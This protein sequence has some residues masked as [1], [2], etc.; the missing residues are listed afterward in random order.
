MITRRRVPLALVILFVAGFLLLIRTKADTPSEDTE[1][2]YTGSI[3]DGVRYSPVLS[4]SQKDTFYLLADT[5][6]ALQFRKTMI[7]FWDTTQEYKADWGKLNETVEGDLEIDSGQ[8]QVLRTSLKPMA[9]VRQTGE[10]IFS[11]VVFGDEAMRR[12]KQYQ[13]DIQ[14][15]QADYQK[16]QDA[17]QAYQQELFDRYQNPDK[18]KDAGPLVE[19]PEPPSLKEYLTDL[20]PA[21][22]VLL[23][24]GTYRMRVIDK[25]GQIVPGSEKN[26]KVFRQRREGISYIVY[27]EQQWTTQKVSREVNDDIYVGEAASLYLQPLFQYEYYADDYWN[28]EQP[29]KVFDR[30]DYWMW[31]NIRPIQSGTL[32]IASDGGK[33]DSVGFQPFYVQQVPGDTLGYQIVDVDPGQPQTRISFSAFKVDLSGKTAFQVSMTDNGQPLPGSQRQVRR[34]EDK[35]AVFLFFPSL[36]TLAFG[37]AMISWRRN[38]T[39]H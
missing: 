7:Y 24:E 27:T 25:D 21:Y 18:Y 2:I 37:W 28:L 1:N 9:L 38:R 5:V 17:E 26:V 22:E 35:S 4:P 15:Y 20:S 10:N 31:V 13:D 11:Q 30:L 36:T 14:R 8:Q 33:A 19:P 3:F 29:Q 34:L 32:R 39:R 12:Y 23:P 6:N 16:Y